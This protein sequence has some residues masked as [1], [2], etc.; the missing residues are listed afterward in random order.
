MEGLTIKLV[1]T[2]EEMEGALGVRFRVF[3][4]EQQ[5]PAEEELDEFDVSATHA[6]AIITQNGE[7]QVI[8]TGRVMY[9]DEDSA[10]RIGRMAVDAEWRHHGIGGQILKFLEEESSTQGVN[11]YVLNAQEYIKSFY[12]AHGYEER[13]LPFM[14][15]NIPHILMRK[16]A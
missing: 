11:T 13:G 7:G 12:A 4:A 6:I 5:V 2:E 8:G 10:A 3:V 9:R 14:E 1:E 15:A 16:E